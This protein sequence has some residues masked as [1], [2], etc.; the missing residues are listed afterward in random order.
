MWSPT[1]F[2]WGIKIFQGVLTKF[3]FSIKFPILE[4]I[5][6]LMKDLVHEHQSIFP[7]WVDVDA[8]PQ[9]LPSASALSLEPS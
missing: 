7:L 4:K 6:D 1:L 8:W 5:V 3:N 2:P 9:P